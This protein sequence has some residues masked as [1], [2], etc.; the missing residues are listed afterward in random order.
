MARQTYQL[1][2]LFFG[3]KGAVAEH[4]KAIKDRARPGTILEGQDMD[5]MLD[6]LRW[7]PHAADKIGVGVRHI[8]VRSNPM[9]GHNEFYLRRVDGSGTDFSYKQCTQPSTPEADFRAALRVAVEPDIIAARNYLFELEPVRYCP[10]TGE[11]ML[12]ADGHIDHKPPNT[13]SQIVKA[14]VL[15]R[16]LNPTKIVVTGRNQDNS[17]RLRLADTALAQDWIEYHRKNAYLRVISQRANLHMVG[18]DWDLILNYLHT[19]DHENALIEWKGKRWYYTQSAELNHGVFVT[20]DRAPEG[21]PCLDGSVMLIEA[22][23]MPEG[24]A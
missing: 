9:M 24:A 11:R 3:S 21:T 22:S 17:F 15:S 13:F 4:A 10:F 7:H 20:A 2:G 5:F 16:R 8:I 19:T 14:F 12:R 1:G 18:Q 23:L 6:L